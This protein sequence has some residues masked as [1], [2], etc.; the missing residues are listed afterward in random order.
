MAWQRQWIG[1]SVIALCGGLVAGCASDLPG[2]AQYQQSPASVISSPAEAR[3]VRSQTPEP[4]G[5]AQPRPLPPLD[6]S[7]YQAPPPQPAAPKLDSGIQQVSAR[8]VVRI[9]ISA[10]VNGVPIFYDEILNM[11]GP[12]LARFGASK[13]A[14]ASEK[15]AEIVKS[16]LEGII[17][18]EVIY[19][20]AMKKIGDNKK[21]Q[22]ELKGF[23]DKEFDKLKDKWIAAKVPEDRMKEMEP[24][25]RRLLQ[26]NL[27]STEFARQRILDQIKG[28]VNMELIREYYESHKNEFQTLDKVVWQNIFIPV[29]PNLPTVDVAKRF[30]ESLIAKCRTLEDFNGLLVYNEGPTKLN[31]HLG[32]G[33]R[34][35]EIQPAE[36]EAH[37]FKLKEGEIGPVIPL[38]TGVHL[39][40]VVKREYQAQLPMDDKVQNAIRKKLE[41]QL[42]DQEYKRIVRELRSRAVV[43]YERP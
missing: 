16:G 35:G 1:V 5:A 34:H 42:A 25:A 17:D 38:T 37:L 22:K 20:D 23:V 7:I 9:S 30:A 33:Q 10:W 2:W 24:I 12:E 8:G 15:M 19:Q 36:L 21:V 27:V 6:P 41:N 40:R 32:L 13:N 11:V 4:P 14:D 3:M 28:W 29:S 18:Q 31:N 39:M 26:R 43:R